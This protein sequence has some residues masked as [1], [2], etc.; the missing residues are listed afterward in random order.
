MSLA[1]WCLL[2]AMILPIAASAPAKVRP[3]FD[4]RNP[5]NPDF[6]KSGFLARAYGAM[7]NG[8]EAFPPFAAAVLAGLTQGG[9]P[10]VVDGL[11]IAFVAARAAYTA[12]YWADRPTLRSAVWVVGFGLTVAILTTPLWAP[13][14]DI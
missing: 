10:A 4:N 9:D 13:V 12:A 3:G 7:Q 8:F 1:L 14:A 2:A 6:W 5:R 11:A